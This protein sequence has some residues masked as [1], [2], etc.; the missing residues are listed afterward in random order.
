MIQIKRG[1]ADKWKALKVPLAAGQPGYNK[2]T[3]EFKIGDGES[4]W[5][6]LPAI[7]GVSE[8][9][10]LC[11]ELDVKTDSGNSPIMTYGPHIP[12]EDTAGQ[13]YL[14]CDDIEPEIDYVVNMGTKD[15][16]VYQLWKSGLARCWISIKNDTAVNT[17]FG[18]LFSS[19]YNTP[20]VKNYP[21]T[22][23]TVPVEHASVMGTG[24]AV[25]QT[26]KSK[27]TVGKSGEYLLVSPISITTPDSYYLNI[28][29]V[30]YWR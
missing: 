26:C 22:F 9:Q 23:I 15:G 20:I 5:S 19:D 28:D 7:S 3:H 13:L 1:S 21:I 6:D 10:V 8:N 14:L 30:G 12:S 2:D 11:A 16:W 29:V 24:N 18:V 17:E 27:N 25:W 4:L